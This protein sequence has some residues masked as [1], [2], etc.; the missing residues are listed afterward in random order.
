MGCQDANKSVS[1]FVLPPFQ[2]AIQQAG[3]RTMQ[4]FSPFGK[5]WSPIVWQ[6]WLD[7]AGLGL[8]CMVPS[9]VT[10]S[11]LTPRCAQC[12]LKL[13]CVLQV[14]VEWRYLLAVERIMLDKQTS[15]FSRRLVKS[16]SLC[17]RIC[18]DMPVASVTSAE[19]GRHAKTHCTSTIKLT[20]PSSEKDTMFSNICIRRTARFV[21]IVRS[22]WRR[23][24]QLA[25]RECANVLQKCA[26]RLSFPA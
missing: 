15:T 4:G 25:T 26:D 2:F 12:N 3:S 20:A 7:G 14:R 24:F 18:A 5:K 16:E 17:W 13:V 22:L 21:F 23:C 6:W 10:V 1:T 8:T 19:S 11:Q 9:L